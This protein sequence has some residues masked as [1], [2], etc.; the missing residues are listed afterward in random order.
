MFI[1]DRCV[2]YLP[3]ILILVLL[4]ALF[5]VF[6]QLWTVYRPLPPG[7]RLLSPSPAISEIAES[8]DVVVVSSEPEGI[9]AAVSAARNGARTLL[10]SERDTVGGLM[11]A[12]ML[13]LID[14]DRGHLWRLTTRGIFLEFYRQA[15]GS[16]FDV[17]RGIRVFERMLEDEELLT[18]IR[19]IDDVLPLMQGNTVTGMRFTYQGQTVEVTAGRVIDATP[20]GDIA[21]AAGA[22]FTFGQEDYG[23]EGTMAATLVMHFS[24]VDWSG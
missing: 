16:P 11:T 14:I 6:I 23:R 12:G 18:V 21:A 2:R 24:G 9:A 8:Y 3:Q 15:G 19:P 1:I 17:E 20:D 22:P 7:E 10:L 5:P 4:A 13:N